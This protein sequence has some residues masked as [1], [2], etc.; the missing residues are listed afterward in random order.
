MGGAV[1]DVVAVR[2][3][4]HVASETG[5]SLPVEDGQPVESFE[6]EGTIVVFSG[7]D[8]L[9]DGV[10]LEG[11]TPDDLGY[12]Q[13][14]DEQLVAETAV[15]VGAFSTPKAEQVGQTLNPVA[16]LSAGELVTS[17][18]GRS[19]LRESGV[20]AE[21]GIEDR[22]AEFL[23]FA[24]AG[25]RSTQL[26][27]SETTL[28]SYAGVVRDGDVLRLVLVHVARADAGDDVA[29][30][31]GVAH[32]KLLTAPGDGQFGTGHLDAVADGLAEADLGPVLLD[33]EDPL[34]TQ[35]GIDA[36]VGEMTTLVSEFERA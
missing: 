33:G 29:F 7:A 32:R 34:V 10:S 22:G 19:L 24:P 6:S 4:V 31:A 26:L 23:G 27:G 12:T 17:D 2:N 1:G 16:R 36:S 9:P 15:T 20:L 28:E 11:V 3:V 13:Q 35:G 25:E 18:R 8:W 30:V 5:P 14:F 21:A